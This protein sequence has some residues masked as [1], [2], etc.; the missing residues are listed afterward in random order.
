MTIGKLID[1]LSQYDPELELKIK[2]AFNIEFFFDSLWQLDNSGD[3]EVLNTY[4]TMQIV[5]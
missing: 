2:D 4:V 3:K 1:E 5:E